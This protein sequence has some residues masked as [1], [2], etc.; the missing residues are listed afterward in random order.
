M[1]KVTKICSVLSLLL[2]IAGI[3]S[4]G[5]AA[6]QSN[7]EHIGI[8]RRFKPDVNIQ[9]FDIDK[10]IELTLPD[11]LGEKL[12]TGDTLLTEE[13]GFAFVMFMDKSVAKVKPNSLLIISG[14]R[15]LT[16]NEGN[17]RIDLMNGEIFLEVQPQG[18]ND[19]EVSTSRSLA[20]VK[21]TEFGSTS[22]GYTWVESGQ[23]D[24]TAF[25][26]GQT[27]SLFENMYGQVDQNGNNIDSGTL[28]EQELTELNEGFDE[29]DE[30]LIQKEII[31]RFRDANGQLREFTIDVFEDVN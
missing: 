1:K 20:S 29:L 31:L 14:N 19:F 6:F 12:F 30:D 25:N 13:D 16:S 2:I 4:E 9:N 7:D 5:V 23:V 10:Y 3:T 21:G 8:V 28:T 11:N 18:E 22:E 17:T 15:E 26:S 24:L 27:V